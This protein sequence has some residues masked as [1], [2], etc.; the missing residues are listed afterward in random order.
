MSSLMKTILLS[1]MAAG[2]LAEGQDTTTSQP[3]NGTAANAL[4]S[5]PIGPS[6]TTLCTADA[7]KAQDLLG[8]PQKSLGYFLKLNGTNPVQVFLE[9]N[10]GINYFNGILLY[11]EQNGKHV[12]SWKT[13]TGQVLITLDGRCQMVNGNNGAT[14]T[15][16]DYRPKGVDGFFTWTPPSGI[17]VSSVKFGGIVY[18][19]DEFGQS[20]WQVISVDQ[21]ANSAQSAPDS[22][23]QKLEDGSSSSASAVHAAITLPLVGVVIANLF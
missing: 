19:N 4:K 2:I 14:L 1:V 22:S 5:S 6:D 8:G 17:D 9:N 18:E 15:H 23:A 12:G 10:K 3:S 13:G 20:G 7:Q 11:A 16:A 21:N